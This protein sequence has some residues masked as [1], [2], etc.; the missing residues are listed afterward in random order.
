MSNPKTG[1]SGGGSDKNKYCRE[2]HI[3]VG[4]HGKYK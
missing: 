2:K 4:F 1:K 3:K